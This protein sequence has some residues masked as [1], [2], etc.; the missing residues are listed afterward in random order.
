M[1]DFENFDKI[2]FS[3]DYDPSIDLTEELVDEL[4]ESGADAPLIDLRSN[5]SEEDIVYRAIFTCKEDGHDIYCRVRVYNDEFVM[6]MD[7]YLANRKEVSM[8]SV[9]D[10]AKLMSVLGVTNREEVIGALAERCETEDSSIDKNL[11]YQFL[12]ENG[13]E[14]EE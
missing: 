10:M 13:L 5:Q 3:T 4:V 12:E 1:I 11:L 8:I 14:Y 6:Y 9:R 2:K 7:R